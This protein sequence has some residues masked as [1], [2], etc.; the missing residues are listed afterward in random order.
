ME[1]LVTKIHEQK[2]KVELF[3][4][5]DIICIQQRDPCVRTGLQIKYLYTKTIA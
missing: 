1:T 3:M 2:V 4:Q 5:T